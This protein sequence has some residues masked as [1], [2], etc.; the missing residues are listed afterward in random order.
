MAPKDGN[1]YSLVFD[2]ITDP[3]AIYDRDFRII[4]VNRALTTTYH[5]SGEEMVGQYCYRAFHGRSRP[6]NKCHVQE[7]FDTGKTH[8][9]EKI[10]HL[11]DGRQ[12]HFVIHSYPIRNAQGNIIQAVEHGRD[13]TEAKALEHQLQVSEERYRTIVE[14][15][16]E[17]IFI[18]DA[19]A[20]RLIFTNNFMAGML[21]YSP[22]ELITQP[23]FSFMDEDA[24]QMVRAQ[25]DRR[26]NGL[27]DVYDLNLRKKDGSPLAVLISAAPL[28]IND[29]SIGSV[30]IVADITHLKAVEADLRAAKKFEEKIINSITDNFLVIDPR[31]YEIVRVNN[32]FLA[33][34][35]REAPAVLGKPCYE[36]MLG[37]HSPCEKDGAL[38]PVQ[39]V[40]K[41]KQSVMLD[42]SYPDAEGRERLLQI[43]AYPLLDPQGEV[44]LVIRL[45]TDVTDKRKMEEALAFRSR[46][47]QKMQH[48]LEMLFEISRQVSAKNSLN[49]L[50]DSLQAII[51]GIFPES[52][53]LFLILDAGG[54]QFLSLEECHPEVVEPLYRF[55]Q[56][57]EESGCMED[58]LRYLRESKDP[59]IIT[60]QDGP[61]PPAFLTNILKCYP[62][63]FGLPIFVQQQIAG[64]FLLG[65]T[66]PK[67]YSRE[68]LHFLH[69]LFAQL[70]SYIRH[71]VMHEV[72]TEQLMPPETEK[73]S[74]GGLIGR[75]K[76][77]QE[78]Y[79]LIRLVS[80][81]DAT[82][83]ITGENG[84]GKE[85]V[86]QAIHRF[87]HR[88]RGPFVVAN[89]SAYSP[90]LLESE[91]FGHERGAFTGAIRQRKGRIE[92]AHGGTLFLDEIGDIS[93]ATQVLLLRFLQ[94]HCF[95]RVGGERS[96]EADVRVLAATNRDLAREVEAGRFRDDLYYRL[97]VIAVHL[98]PLRERKEDIPLL[99]HHFL[100][101]YNLKEKK[102]V[103]EFSSRA[104]QTLMD[105]DWP[106]NV[107]Q[108]ENA[109][110][111]AVILAQGDVMRRRHLP[112]FLKEFTEDAVNTSLAENERRLIMRVLL[113]SNWNKHA[114]A[115]RLQLSRSTLY[116]KIRRYGLEKKT[117]AV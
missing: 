80:G 16:R 44:D 57:L 56:E 14:N 2:S 22:E 111:H 75:A 85:L 90:T 25:L 98:P 49:E 45:E 8:R 64:Y 61:R 48:Q 3:L 101:K 5:R 42:K 69:V 54:N 62:A 110:S 12:R 103:R 105:Y 51:K 17:G 60:H 83:F 114:A 36:I 9:R 96:I 32:S 115:H 58:Y 86:A 40:L 78:I 73:I 106:G 65:S 53:A 27:A 108:L 99:I 107:R 23:M 89:C 10:I 29:T 47:L 19:E 113:E 70:A 66:A 74:C 6:C 117:N 112:R 50:I 77:M 102:N 46:E 4:L 37:K 81:S 31:T 92:R 71:L 100:K 35:G 68:D 18:L 28:R 87:S 97:N 20:G 67:E 94:D 76:K 55:L 11:P 24:V 13:L 109:V 88:H 1:F 41:T 79:D 95:E 63:W 33:R 38:C 26:R 93:P 7:V 43:S 91:L 34:V 21:G 59:Q 72:K 104:M 52:H 30:G 116:S 82:I 15:V 84:T 39:Q